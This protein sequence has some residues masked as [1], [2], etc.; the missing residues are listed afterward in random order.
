[1]VIFQNRKKMRFMDKSL[2]DFVN[3]KL[4]EGAG[5]RRFNV[6]TSDVV[7]KHMFDAIIKQL[8]EQINNTP[9]PIHRDRNYANYIIDDGKIIYKTKEKK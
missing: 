7:V 3:K 9:V 2:V 8:V 6:G 4:D 1:M 5:E